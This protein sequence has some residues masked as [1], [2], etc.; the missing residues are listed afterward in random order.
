[1]LF[2]I[3][4]S[5]QFEFNCTLWQHQKCCTWYVTK[6]M[7]INLD[8]ISGSIQPAECLLS[9]VDA[10][11]NVSC[12]VTW[13]RNHIFLYGTKRSQSIQFKISTIE[14]A[15]GI[16]YKLLW[17]WS[18][19]KFLSQFYGYLLIVQI[20]SFIPSNLIYKA[21]NLIVC[22][23][24]K[25]TFLNQSEPNIAH[26]APWPGRDRR[27]CMVRN[28]LTFKAFFIFFVASECR[29]HDRRWL[30]AQVTRDR[31]IS[32]ILAGACATS[33]KRHC[34]GRQLSVLTESVLHL[35]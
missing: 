25:F 28:F 30:P 16:W 18:V 22:T 21:E 27:V 31:V 1:M 17:S 20:N 33:R 23:L 26:I 35:E 11:C 2:R 9:V 6:Y 3:V 13:R 29:F 5:V 24:Y 19:G 14:G 7:T 10:S 32:M 34:S 8:I 4:H 15:S 12:F